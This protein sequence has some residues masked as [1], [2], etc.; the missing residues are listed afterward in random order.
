[1]KKIEELTE[2]EILALTSDE[3]TFMIK[4]KKVEEGVKLI[5]CP[6]LP[7]YHVI[8][9]PDKILYT[10]DFLGITLAFE[11]IN[12]LS[13]MLDLIRQ[14][15]TFKIDYT[16]NSIYYAKRGL[17]Y[18]PEKW[19]EITSKTVYSVELYN[20]VKS[21]LIENANM[22][23]EYDVVYKEYSENYETSKWIEDEIN[24]RV[25]EVTAKYDKLN[26]YLFMFKNDYLPLANSDK[27]VAIA[28]MDKAYALTEEEKEYIKSN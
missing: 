6:E 4:V 11:D 27:M 3:V 20:K 13:E 18:C 28:F 9:K 7:A 2:Q 12:K 8:P 19:D 1:M 15:N 26:R 22:K 10:C 17:G 14:S 21:L 24:N 25:Y 16:A 5:N 23:K